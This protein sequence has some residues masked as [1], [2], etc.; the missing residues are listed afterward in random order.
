MSS[1]LLKEK[2]GR[3][4]ETIA[5]FAPEAWTELYPIPKKDSAYVLAGIFK[6][7]T[8]IYCCSSYSRSD[9]LLVDWVDSV[10]TAQRTILLR[11]VNKAFE[12]DNLRWCLTWPLAVLGYA[13]D[14][15]SF[16]ERA[17]VSRLLAEMGSEYSPMPP[18]V[19]VRLERF[20]KSKDKFWDQC[21]QEPVIFTV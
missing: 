11:L 6:A 15:G 8:S 9:A 16:S 17:M 18:R 3:I 1:E 7:A 20:W 2:A 19:R 13:V 14:S 5:E 12:K 10:K 21:W 4:Y